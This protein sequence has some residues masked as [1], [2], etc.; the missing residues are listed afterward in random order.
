[1]TY[2]LALL[3]HTG[4]FVR[5]INRVSTVQFRRSVRALTCI[6]RFVVQ[7]SRHQVQVVEIGNGCVSLVERSIY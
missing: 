5:K 3:A 6:Q 1:M 4:Q 2:G 7:L